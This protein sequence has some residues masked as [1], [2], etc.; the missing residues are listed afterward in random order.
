MNRVLQR[1]G[2]TV[3]TPTTSRVLGA[4]GLGGVF[5]A[6]AVLTAG[7]PALAV[8]YLIVGFAIRD[9]VVV[10][11]LWALS[12]T[13]TVASFV[14]ISQTYARTVR[15]RRVVARLARSAPSED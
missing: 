5:V 2:T 15:R 14:L 12:A 7:L 13:V 6:T 8:A 1:S 3:A 10:L 11:A 9:V 4:L